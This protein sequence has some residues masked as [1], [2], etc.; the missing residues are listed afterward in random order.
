MKIQC[1]GSSI[2]P[3]HTR[4]DSMRQRGGSS[5]LG[6]WRHLY[7]KRTADP[8]APPPLLLFL[9]LA[10]VRPQP[11][12]PR[13]HTAGST[14]ASPQGSP[15]THVGGWVR[16]TPGGDEAPAGEAR[17]TG[18]RTSV[19]LRVAAWARNVRGA[20]R[21]DAMGSGARTLNAWFRGKSM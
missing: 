19:C 7:S 11:L 16:G 17:Q 20:R 21:K 10:P 3:L 13:S 8:P 5:W 6:L 1:R 15:V 14:L 4:L 2:L 9:L 18:R 12:C